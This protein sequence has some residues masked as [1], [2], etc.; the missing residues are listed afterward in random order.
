MRT[1]TISESALESTVIIGLSEKRPKV[2]HWPFPRPSGRFAIDDRE[3]GIASP[4]VAGGFFDRAMFYEKGVVMNQELN[5]GLVLVCMVARA[6][7]CLAIFAFVVI[8]TAFEASLLK[9]LPP[10]AA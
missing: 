10:R 5:M 9:E 6:L 3:S 1:K 2:G 4:K 7:F 8:H